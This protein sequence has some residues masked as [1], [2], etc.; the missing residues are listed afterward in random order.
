MYVTKAL[1]TTIPFIVALFRY[2]ILKRRTVH[3]YCKT[4]MLILL[5][6]LLLSTP[7]VKISARMMIQSLVI[8]VLNLVQ[9][10]NL[11]CLYLLNPLCSSIPVL[12][13]LVILIISVLKR[14]WA[15]LECQEPI[16]L[17]LLSRLP[18]NIHDEKRPK[19][20]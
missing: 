5:L 2:M 10:K 14:S 3:F 11:K 8:I 4:I 18:L 1:V 12:I 19:I 7:K 9:V 13:Y 16:L 6:I 20:L 15:Y 17:I